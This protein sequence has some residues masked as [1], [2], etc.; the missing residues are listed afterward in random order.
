MVRR[1]LKSAVIA[2]ASLSMMMG[3]AIPAVAKTGRPDTE[4][5]WKLE[6]QAWSFQDPKANT[7]KGW[8]VYKG[9]W[10]FLD[11]STGFLKTGWL[12]RNGKSYFFNTEKGSREGALLSG[13][14]WIDG[15]CYYFSEKDDESYGEL[16]KSTTTADGYKLDDSGRWVD[17]SGSAY[18]VAGH[19]ISAS[20]TAQQVAGAS[21]PVIME[22]SPSRSGSSSGRTSGGSAGRNTASQTDSNRKG[23]DEKKTDETKPEKPE[24]GKKEEET[25]PEKPEE[26]KKEDETKP[27]KPEENEQQ[28][29]AVL[30]KAVN[31][32][33]LTIAVPKEIM[34]KL[35]AVSLTDPEDRP[36]SYTVSGDGQGSIIS[37][38]REKSQI[39]I[40]ANQAVG[41]FKTLSRPGKYTLRL[42]TEEGPLEDFSFDVGTEEK[43][44]DEPD[45]KEF[46]PRADREEGEHSL[47]IT[48]KDTFKG[49][50]AAFLS[51]LNAVEVN[52]VT[53]QKADSLS[54]VE[55]G[56]GLY[57][58]EDKTLYLSI[59]KEKVGEVTLRA[60]GFMH[61]IVS[62]Q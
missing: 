45:G 27:E 10:Y 55:A 42:M 4:G 58:V 49:T 59:P 12:S 56:E 60:D 3:N 5:Q 20:G 26:G 48:L 28:S 34:T 33:D 40:K 47:K 14:N 13:W 35:L 15:Y 18:Y 36:V 32:Q 51:K 9:D 11:E 44:I 16:Q 2:V 25:K 52:G 31:G 39:R 41:N 43:Q 24:E 62:A 22:S 21:R 8:M 17:E 46:P 53:Y 19:G 50:A 37:L 30:G 23:E 54:T 57:F 1:A 7:V 38:D 6:K 29:L 61:L